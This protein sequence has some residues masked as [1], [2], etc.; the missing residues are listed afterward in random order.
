M[1]TAQGSLSSALYVTEI[2][3]WFDWMRINLPLGGISLP[4]EETAVA[5]I[6][7]AIRLANRVQ[8][9]YRHFLEPIRRKFVR[10]A[11]VYQ[12]WEL[13]SRLT[14]RAGL[15]THRGALPWI[16][17][18][19]YLGPIG[20]SGRHH[21]V[22]GSD[23]FTYVVT[24]PSDRWFESLCATE[25]ICAELA[26]LLGFFVPL[27]AVVTLSPESLKRAD[28]NR[29]EWDHATATKY[30]AK[31]CC[32][33]RYVEPADEISTSSSDPLPYRA[34]RPLL[35][36]ALAFDIWVCN[37]RPEKFVLRC[38]EGTGRSAILRFDHSGCFAGAD[39]SRYLCRPEHVQLCPRSYLSNS[40]KKQLGHWL[41]RIRALD[42]NPI[43]QLTFEMPPCWYGGRRANL[44]DLVESV[45]LRKSYLL[46][47]IEKLFPSAARR[48]D[49]KKPC[50]SDLGCPQG[51]ACKLSA[52]SKKRPQTCSTGQL[53][54]GTY[55]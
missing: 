15:P 10:S 28:A 2:S 21:I 17:A 42:M 16:S 31:P 11:I 24:I 55:S 35:L 41:K 48:V 50:R 53:R 7:H 3:E 46:A 54:S 45:G 38:K 20:A 49:P 32:G 34:N 4:D 9:T 12:C 52:T 25:I 13:Q 27:S 8:G 44:I 47:E 26:R 22:E 6:G 40:D 36:G 5:F 18:T 39:W 19:A 29:P 43:W 33:F 30:A 1:S 14:E 51:L 37:F 23:G